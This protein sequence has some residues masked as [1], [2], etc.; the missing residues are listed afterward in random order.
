MRKVQFSKQKYRVRDGVGPHEH[1]DKSGDRVM[2]GPGDEFYPTKHELEAFGFKFEP[3]VKKVEY[4]DDFEEPQEEPSD[5]D[6]GDEEEAD[7]APD[8]TPDHEGDTSEADEGTEEADEGAD[9]E[10]E[11]KTEE[12]VE[13]EALQAED[14]SSE[15]AFKEWEDAGKP[16]LSDVQRTGHGG[17]TYNADDV[18]GATEG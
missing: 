7:E 2:L 18:R 6:D 14:F 17:Q 10:E 5:T 8:I 16:D 15:V 11:T 4:E 12:E 1:I 3:A 13:E 9:T